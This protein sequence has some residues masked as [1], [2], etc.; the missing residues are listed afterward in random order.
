MIIDKTAPNISWQKQPDAIYGAG[1]GFH[2][3]PITSEV[4]TT[5]SVYI[6]SIT[7]ENL[8]WTLTSDHKNFDTQ[9]TKNQALWDKLS[10]GEHKF[11][12]VFKD[13]A[14]NETQSSSNVFV[15]DRTA[16]IGKISYSK[17]NWTNSDVTATLT[18]NEPIKT[19][20]GW[21][22][23][24][25]TEFTKKYTNNLT[26]SVTLTDIAG[27]QS[28]LAVSINN[29]DKTKPVISVDDLTLDNDNNILTSVFSAT[30]SQ[31]GIKTTSYAVYNTA[32]KSGKKLIANSSANGKIS[33]DIS[34]LPNGTYYLH[35][36][37]DDNAGNM[38]GDNSNPVA[39]SFKIYRI[40]N[41]D[42]NDSG[43]VPS[44]VDTNNSGSSTAL[45]QIVRNNGSAVAR[46]DSNTVSRI[47]NVDTKNQNEKAQADVNQLSENNSENNNTAVLGTEDSKTNKDN[48]R[49]S[50]INLILAALTVLMSLISLAGLVTKS[51]NSKRASIIRGITLIPAIG[52]VIALFLIENISLAMG[53]FNA[54]T[55]LFA[56][57][58][59]IQ[60]A[61]L[62][63]AKRS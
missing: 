60:I 63:S 32:D 48:A 36:F 30:D 33:I 56:V 25:D 29:I 40:Q 2:V 9:N 23:V 26:D 35:V 61:L 52:S 59:A 46:T 58:A 49:W 15:V 45:S 24:S 1:A 31:S 42:N 37:A 16:P 19:P 20:A 50:V 8:V 12:A 22:R 43:S 28:T 38:T 4:G 39:Y 21:L 27:N 11:I 51:K 44:A 13:A 10:D 3:R 62:G 53:W 41:N 5:K 18:S 54:W 17:I 14:G 7:P 47:A 55:I 6:D 34:K 57:I